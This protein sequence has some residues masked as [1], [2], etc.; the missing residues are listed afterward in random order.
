MEL[1]TLYPEHLP[2]TYATEKRKKQHYSHQSTDVFLRI[3][4]TVQAHHQ[5]RKQLA[6]QLRFLRDDLV[7][8]GSEITPPSSWLIHRLVDICFCHQRHSKQDTPQA[9][10]ANFLQHL[11][12]SLARYHSSDEKPKYGKV[13]SI[14]GLELLFPNNDGYSVEDC[15]GFTSCALAYLQR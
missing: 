9:R 8:N 12:H 11:H 3:H 1:S 6:K 14:L 15:Q 2:I 4:R 5:Q 13:Q 7:S 10:L